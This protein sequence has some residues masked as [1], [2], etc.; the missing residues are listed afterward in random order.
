MEGNYSLEDHIAN[1]QKT[2]ELLLSLEPDVSQPNGWT[3]KEILI[4]LY[5]WD[6]EFIKVAESK[7]AGK[8]EFLFSHQEKEIDMDDWNVQQVAKY[9]DLSLKEVKELFKKTREKTISLFKRV[10]KQPETI[11][12]EDSILRNNKI[13]TL[14]FH[15]K[16]HLEQCGQKVDL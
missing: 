2:S 6:K 1:F 12:N 4:H 10:I 3:L 8:K 7:I 15:D 14:W 5:S 13:V 16:H 11:E 9:N